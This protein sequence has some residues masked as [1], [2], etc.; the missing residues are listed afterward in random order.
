MEILLFEKCHCNSAEEAFIIKSRPN[1]QPT[2][3][4]LY[5]LVCQ[6][7]SLPAVVP[8]LICHDDTL[9]SGLL[10]LAQA[11][12]IFEMTLQNSWHSSGGRN[13][14]ARIISA[15]GQTWKW[16]CA[17]LVMLGSLSPPPFSL[18]LFLSAYLSLWLKW[19]HN[20]V[21]LPADRFQMLMAGSWCEGAAG[22]WRRVGGGAIHSRWG[23]NPSSR[24]ENPA[25]EQR[26]GTEASNSAITKT[27]K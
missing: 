17:L 14:V 13:R 9:S 4:G 1:K 27:L 12:Y 25:Q 8:P 19:T 3:S 24:L 7:F 18:S 22:G 11:C 21:C 26:C 20:K 23:W 6:H 2:N 10:K 5:P 15:K 16:L